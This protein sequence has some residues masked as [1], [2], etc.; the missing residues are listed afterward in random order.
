MAKFRYVVC[1]GCGYITKHASHGRCA[2]CAYRLY[3]SNSKDSVYEKKRAEYIRNKNRYRRQQ[4]IY[5]NNNKEKFVEK[6]NRRRASKYKTSSD[7]Y[8]YN[9]NIYK[10]DNWICGICLKRVDKRLKYPHPMSKSLDHIIP[11][12]K[13]GTH[14]EDNLQLSHLICNLRKG[15]KILKKT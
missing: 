12:S 11:L 3:V 9:N 7:K 2:R 10:R 6:S 13:G 4:R 5:Y 8:I 15:N 14:T 1:G